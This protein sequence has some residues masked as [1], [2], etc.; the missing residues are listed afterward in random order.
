MS[1][2]STRSKIRLM[3]SDGFDVVAE[4]TGVE[5]IVNDSINYVARGGTLLVY[6]VYADS[7]RVSWSPTSIFVNE[8][9]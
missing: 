8:I 6:G 1:V 7:A 9:K 3:L 4:C 5:T 2:V